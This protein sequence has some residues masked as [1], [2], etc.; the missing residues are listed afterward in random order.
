MQEH[1]L[2]VKNS[3][4]IYQIEARTFKFGKARDNGNAAKLINN[5][6]LTDLDYDRSMVY[7][8]IDNSIG[9]IRMSFMKYACRVEKE[10]ET[11]H[12]DENEYQITHLHFRLSSK[13]PS[14]N[15]DGFDSDCRE[16]II[17]KVVSDFLS[18]SLPKEADLYGQ[19]AIEALKNAERKL[20]FK[21]G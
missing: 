7:G 19:K 14:C 8:W 9:N 15:G 11:G 5:V 6:K 18:L 3:D 1:I 17:N 16:Y 21:F 12:T 2:T 10:Y 20:Y 4:I 13:W